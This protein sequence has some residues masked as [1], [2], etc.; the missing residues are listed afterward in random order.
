MYRNSYQNCKGIRL[1]F[2]SVIGTLQSGSSVLTL[3]K[4]TVLD[5][6]VRFYCYK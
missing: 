4:E 5:S 6:E 2:L 1:F 3:S